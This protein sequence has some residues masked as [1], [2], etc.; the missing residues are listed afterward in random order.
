MHYFLFHS[1]L[2]FEERYANEILTDTATVYMGFY[3]YMYDGYLM[4]GYLRDS[5]LKYVHRQLG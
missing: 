1:G 4:V 2:R 5:E 3:E